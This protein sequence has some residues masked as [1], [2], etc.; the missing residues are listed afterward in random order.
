M[1]L[2]ERQDL[3][4]SSASLH[5]IKERPRYQTQEEKFI[6]KIFSQSF[7][8]QRKLV[9]SVSSGT[10]SQSSHWKQHAFPRGSDLCLII[11]TL[12]NAFP[13]GGSQRAVGVTKRG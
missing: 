4:T 13:A 8:L 6:F 10:I 5:T 1:G 2:Q 12:R 7:C 9:S 3:K 11:C